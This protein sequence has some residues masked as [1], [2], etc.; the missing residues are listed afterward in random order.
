M[1]KKASYVHINMHISVL[2]YMNKL[3]FNLTTEAEQK[4]L[5]RFSNGNLCII[6]S[7]I[8]RMCVTVEKYL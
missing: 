5:E 7:I 8:A 2:V 4:Q 1:R 6:F 3:Y